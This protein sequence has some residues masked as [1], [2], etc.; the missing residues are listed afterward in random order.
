MWDRDCNAFRNMIRLAEPVLGNRDCLGEF[1]AAV[2]QCPIQDCRSGPG[3]NV[4]NS[5][6]TMARPRSVGCKVIIAPR[7]SSGSSLRRLPLRSRFL[8]P[9]LT[10][11]LR[12][13][14]SAW[15]H[16]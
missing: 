7:P 12:F 5:I 9:P 2:T 14:R 11:G 3:M 1:R 6:L 16:W 15:L 13:S 8:H 10:S 4:V